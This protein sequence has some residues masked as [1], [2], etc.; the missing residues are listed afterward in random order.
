M[1]NDLPGFIFMEKQVSFSAY[2]NIIVKEQKHQDDNMISSA[3]IQIK[4][5]PAIEMVSHIE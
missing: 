1:N 5:K 3:K 2:E 4:S